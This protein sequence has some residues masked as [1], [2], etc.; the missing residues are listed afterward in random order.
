MSNLISNLQNGLIN[1]EIY[2]DI[3][4]EE[5]I[6]L[7]EEY[8]K[9]PNDFIDYK[10]YFN[11]KCIED[12]KIFLVS[13][14]I[15]R[16]EKTFSQ[17]QIYGNDGILENKILFLFLRYKKNIPNFILKLKINKNN[18][19]DYI[20]EVKTL[21]QKI[22]VFKDLNKDTSK[23]QKE[24][25]IYEKNIFDIVASDIQL[26][27]END[28][29][30]SLL[31]TF[32]KY[33]VKNNKK[34]I[35]IKI[36]YNEYNNV[37]IS[38]F[39]DYKYENLDDMI[40]NLKSNELITSQEL[41]YYITKYKIVKNQSFKKLISEFDDIQLTSELINNYKNLIF[42][43]KDED[44][45]N[46][47]VSIN[48]SPSQKPIKNPKFE[49][50][51]K[52]HIFIEIIEICEQ[53]FSQTYL[54][55]LKNIFEQFDMMDIYNNIKERNKIQN[56]LI[57]EYENNENIFIKD[58]IEKIK[59]NDNNL[60]HYILK[61]SINQNLNKQEYND[62]KK[63]VKFFK[64]LINLEKN[65]ANGIINNYI[66]KHNQ[67]IIS[68][69]IEFNTI[70]DMN[71]VEKHLKNNPIDE[72]NEYIL[73]QLKLYNIE[74]RQEKKDWIFIS[75]HSFFK[76]NNFFNFMIF[77]KDLEKKIK[78]LN[79][80]DINNIFDELFDSFLSEF[81]NH[82]IKCINNYKTLDLHPSAN[83]LYYNYNDNKKIRVY[84]NDPIE[85]IF[86]KIKNNPKEY[87]YIFQKLL[88]HL[89]NYQ[90][91]NIILD[92]EETII[93]KVQYDIFLI[94]YINLMQQ[95]NNKL[96]KPIFVNQI[97]NK[98]KLINSLL[99]VKEIKGALKQII[100]FNKKNNIINEN[101]IKIL[102]NN[103]K[104][105][106]FLTFKKII[107][108]TKGITKEDKI[109][110]LKF[111][112]LFTNKVKDDLKVKKINISRNNQNKE[113]KKIINDTSKELNRIFKSSDPFPYKYVST[114]QKKKNDF[115]D[116][117]T[118][119][120]S[121]IKAFEKNDMTFIEI[122]NFKNA[123]RDNKN[124][125][126]YLNLINNAINR[127]K[128]F[129]NEK[130]NQ[131]INFETLYNNLSSDKNK[132]KIIA[133][134]YHKNIDS[135]DFWNK[136]SL[137]RKTF[138]DII[139]LISIMFFFDNLINMN[140]DFDLKTFENKMNDSII[141]KKIYILKSGKVSSIKSK[142][143]NNDIYFSSNN[144]K[145]KR[146]DFILYDSLINHNVTI[147]KGNY[148]GYI[149]RL[150][151]LNDI[152]NFSFNTKENKENQKKQFSIFND[153][154]SDLRNIKIKLKNQDKKNVFDDLE[155]NEL[156]K[157]RKD[158]LRKKNIQNLFRNYLGKKIKINQ[159]YEFNIKIN[160]SIRKILN[161]LETSFIKNL[162]FQRLKNINYNLNILYNQK[163]SFIHKHKQQ[164]IIRIHEG[165]KSAKNITFTS[166]E[167]KFNKDDILNQEIKHE[168]LIQF[169][170]LIIDHKYNNLY[171]FFKYIF[172]YNN[173]SD[174]NNNQYFIDIYK[175]AI[176]IFNI[177]K[178][179]NIN[180]LDIKDKIIED[181]RKL[182][183]NIG[184]MNNKINL[185][186]DLKKNK[187]ILK[188]YVLLK[189][190]R[191]N[192]LD[193]INID[194]N[195]ENLM[196]YKSIKNN[197]FKN[198]IDQLKKITYF[199]INNN[200]MKNDLKNI[201]KN[202]INIQNNIEKIKKDDNEKIKK[203]FYNIK[204]DIDS[205]ISD[206]FEENPKI[207]FI[208]YINY[209]FIDDD[210]ESEEYS[211]D[212][213]DIM[214]ELDEIEIDSDDERINQREKEL[215]R[216]LTWIELSDLVY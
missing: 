137:T 193:S 45:L 78:F 69:L 95:I 188:K 105:L 99:P 16:I 77:M 63:E 20:P 173:I 102:I 131:K 146:N 100:A 187:L 182:N 211:I 47:G 94:R 37:I 5:I 84:L 185:K 124:E 38:K 178:K 6:N 177:N 44:N 121:N 171:D 60:N 200:D 167:F 92:I 86:F 184:I 172:N 30:S 112:K 33:C 152:K 210:D 76:N 32:I 104:H 83:Q 149:G 107:N 70:I 213:N 180:K 170:N 8:K 103:W 202:N 17:Q 141:N 144:I 71:K 80:S 36:N 161:E 127:N 66:L 151:K 52:K 148:K 174:K 128:I 135:K 74:K 101:G 106:N 130:Y 28:N 140:I 199:K 11:E 116:N 191:I 114:T 19:L 175:E 117:Y 12:Y 25:D 93:D 203:L 150:M 133:K 183:K 34:F 118:V 122:R 53:P 40:D 216:K 165:E 162:R 13:N 59:K 50:N 41:S 194:I 159:K 31:K 2:K 147:I 89:F 39:S 97:N 111:I 23:F 204:N 29:I 62:L 14:I 46:D 72:N 192:Q 160:P 139:N 49:K 138:T 82:Y 54:N 43:Y 61:K 4:N 3:K 24:L 1:T 65:N 10:N 143:Q 195:K 113:Q 56:E 96:D 108:K 142:S 212:F 132:I 7:I 215:G 91:Y 85:E 55:Y 42:E 110:A 88:N 67:Y 189:N 158:I 134:K 22:N 21:R 214:D 115:F 181:L 136:I 168:N 18:F 79:N 64:D 15:N 207:K 164:Y 26:F 58:I 205:M 169:Q 154:I 9:D 120:I 186:K 198:D 109:D 119:D 35:N 209:N 81:F 90:Y 98:K 196:I 73:S 157:F 155:L 179:N 68:E 125:N 201:K 145:L 48:N 51:I 190:K 87:Q 206:I 166:D 163:K 153:N 57:I 129:L 208:D 123:Y 176:N 27:L 126:I 197:K 156:I 75:V